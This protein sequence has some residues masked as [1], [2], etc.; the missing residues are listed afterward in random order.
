MP[1]IVSQ[2][3]YYKKFGDYY[4]N[5]ADYIEDRFGDPSLEAP[6]PVEIPDDSL[7]S[8]EDLGY[9]LFAKDSY[10]DIDD[11]N[12]F[13]NYEYLP[14]DSTDRVAVYKSDVDNEVVYA[15]QGTELEDQPIQDFFRNAGIAIGG[16]TTELF[17]PTY[18]AYKKHI[19]NTNKKYST[20]RPVVVGHSQGGTYAGLIGTTNPNYK[21]ITYNA[22]SGFIPSSMDFKCLIGGCDNIKQYRVVGDW[23]SANQITNSFQL[24][25]K[26]ADPE[27]ERQAEQAER[28]YIP[29]D[30]LLSHGINNFIGR[31]ETNLKND[32]GTYGR[33]IARR[34]GDVAGLVAIPAIAKTLGRQAVQATSVTGLGDAGLGIGRTSSFREGLTGFSPSTPIGRFLRRPSGESANLGQQLF[35]EESALAQGALAES[36]MTL[37]ERIQDLQR[38]S[39][40]LGT[41]IS[42]SI[43]GRGSGTS[44]LPPQISNL[45]PTSIAQDIQTSLA[46]STSIPSVIPDIP[47]SDIFAGAATGLALPSL[48]NLRQTIQPSIRTIWN[49]VKVNELAGAAIGAGIGDVVG[50]L[51][52]DVFIKP[53]E[54]ELLP[55]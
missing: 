14:Q 37:A 11:R 24:R 47:A 13:N 3:D 35:A 46:R 54:E 33:K 5:T 12:D 44:L 7:P 42:Q 31:N 25:P 22:G 20:Y 50:G 51:S 45:S 53:A 49:F 34:V 52:Y 48:S 38:T 43:I 15:I 36:E 41:Q 40:I 16:P 55:F 27:L 1:P 6:E 17:D 2:A 19:E 30:Y 28:L 4:S 26:V 10:R 23:A 29:S 18:Y 39:D 21:T 9:A 8:R 32:Y